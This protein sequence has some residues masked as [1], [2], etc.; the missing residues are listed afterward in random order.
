MFMKFLKD[1]R[2]A[3]AIEYGLITGS[4]AFVIIGSVNALGLKLKSTFTNVSTNIR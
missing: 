3:T 1:E 2:G 4:I